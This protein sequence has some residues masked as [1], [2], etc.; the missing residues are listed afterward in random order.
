MLEK[1]FPPSTWGTREE[2]VSHKSEDGSTIMGP[3]PSEGDY[4]M[5]AGPFEKI[6]ELADLRQ[7]IDMHRQ[8]MQSQPSNYANL[9]KQTILDQ[10]TARETRRAKLEAD[11][12]YMRK[13]ELVPV[14]KSGSL[15]AQR[16][17]NQLNEATGD[18]SHLGA[19]H[20]A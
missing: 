14:L 6:P 3:Y 18:R 13:N 1:W 10:E 15:A 7:S 20:D 2:W 12:A 11:L 8:A 16:F 17:R 9:L 4:W 19:V 5:L